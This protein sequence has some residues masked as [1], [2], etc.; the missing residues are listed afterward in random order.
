VRQSFCHLTTLCFWR[1]IAGDMHSILFSIQPPDENKIEFSTWCKVVESVDLSIRTNKD[2][3][4]LAKG[5]WLLTGA[6]GFQTLGKAIEKAATLHFRYRVLLIE[7]A[8]DW[9]PAAK[10]GE[11]K[12]SQTTP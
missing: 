5:A 1:L 3:E 9:T 6:M 11:A 8:T 10:T 7:Q 2:V 12:P 4:I